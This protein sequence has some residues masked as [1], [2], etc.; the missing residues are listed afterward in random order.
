MCCPFGLNRIDLMSR[1]LSAATLA[2]PVR[3]TTCA[4]GDLVVYNSL[5]DRVACW[6]LLTL[7]HP[8]QYKVP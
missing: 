6:Y 2:S 7:H 3:D 5:T 1:E 8:Y 4:P